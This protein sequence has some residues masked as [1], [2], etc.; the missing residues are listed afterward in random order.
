MDATNKLLLEDGYG[1]H[2]NGD[3]NQA[4]AC[5]QK[6]LE[7]EP[8]NFNVQLLLGTLLGQ[9]QSYDEALKIFDNAEKINDESGELFY[10]RGIVLNALKR[11]QESIKN[12]DR[13]IQLQ[14]D[15]LNAYLNRGYTKSE[16]HLFPDAISDFSEVIK[17]NPNHDQAY[18]YRATAYS[19]I[20]EHLLA[21]H[22]YE[23]IDEDRYH[24]LSQKI[25]EKLLICDWS[26]YE[27]NL[28]ELER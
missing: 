20:N 18:F 5:Y 7:N 15:F 8:N 12:Y 22:D 16:V 9:R 24:L 26:D 27:E 25:Y 3:L 23:K 21:I 13:A 19:K 4:E 11:Y 28:S 2:K 10:N 6:F 17:L 14:P 1:F